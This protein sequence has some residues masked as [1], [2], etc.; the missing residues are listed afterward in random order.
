MMPR[1]KRYALAILKLRSMTNEDFDLADRMINAIRQAPRLP[2][3]QRDCERE[4]RQPTKRSGK[5][6]AR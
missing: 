1:A 5:K 6:T 4:L 3:P 2:P